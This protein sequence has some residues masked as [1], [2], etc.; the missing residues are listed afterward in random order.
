MTETCPVPTIST[1]VVRFWQEWSAGK[2]RWRGRIEHIP[3]GK[4]AA[5]LH[6]EVMWE[7]IQGFGIVV[8]D[9]SQSGTADRSAPSSH[10]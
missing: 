2:A 7:F 10:R 8:D 6:E 4:S 5:F 9:A 1:F 3:S